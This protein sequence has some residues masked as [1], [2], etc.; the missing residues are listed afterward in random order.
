MA[1]NLENECVDAVNDRAPNTLITQNTRV[2][3][4]RFIRQSTVNATMFLS[5]RLHTFIEITP[6]YRTDVTNK[7]MMQCMNAIEHCQ[8]L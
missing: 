5:D 1:S 6:N 8:E 4:A 2:I 3:R 7:I